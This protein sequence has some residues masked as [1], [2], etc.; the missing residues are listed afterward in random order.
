MKLSTSLAASVLCFFFISAT[1][2]QLP[3]STGP[4]SIYALKNTGELLWYKDLIQNGTNGNCGERGWH[5]N[6]GRRIGD[7]LQ[8]ITQIISEGNGIL[9]ALKSTGDL[10][11]LRDIWQNGKNDPD[12]PL[13]WDARSLEPIGC[14]W[15][16]KQ[17]VSGGNGIIYALKNTGE[18]LWYKDL[19]QNGKNGVCGEHGWD[20]KSG[21]QI[22]CGWDFDHIFS[23]G[24]GVIYAI[25][26][27]GE[28]FW[29]KDVNRNGTNGKCG[30]HGWDQNSGKQVG[31]GWSGFKEFYTGS[32]GIIYALKST[33]ELLWYR[34]MF[35]N[36]T[37]G[38]CGELGWNANSGKQIGCGWGDFK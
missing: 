7:G 3:S 30:E 25:K 14:G 21:N 31:C 34:D 17:I 12:A 29:Y 23:G 26:S 8:D 18:L 19:Y 20:P 15:G 32:N 35:R 36:G 24:N 9:Y 22:G 27:T 33:G 37:N 38:K 5:S 13:G 4:V 11:W 28:L 16:F 2:A 10:L 1:R 6:S